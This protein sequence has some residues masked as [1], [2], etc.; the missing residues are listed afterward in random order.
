MY[1]PWPMVLRDARPH[2]AA[3]A[4]ALL[5]LLPA[6]APAVRAADTAA[7]TPTARAT[8][9]APALEPALEPAPTVGYAVPIGGA[10]RFDNDAVWSRLVQLSGGNGARWVVL[11]TAASDPAHTAAQIVAVLQRHGARAEPI[12]VAARL[13]PADVATEV[14]NPRWL[15]KVQA[16]RG[17]FF[18]GGAQERIVDA[19][20]PGGQSTPLLEAIRALQQRGGVVAGTSA[21]AAVMSSVMFRDAEDVMAVLRGSLRDGAEVDRGLGFVGAGLLVDQHFLRRGRI[22]RLLPL[23]VSREIRLGLGVDEDTAAIVHGHDVEVIGA[24]GAL[25]VDLTD[26][27]SDP[28]AGAFN[29]AGARLSYL[30]RGDH[31]DLLHRRV[32]PAAEKLAGQRLDPAARDFAPYH[33]AAPFFTDILADS[34][35]VSAMIHVV[36]GRDAEVRGLAAT[37]DRSSSAPSAPDF[38]FRLYRGMGTL[39][40]YTGEFGGEAYTLENVR[41]DVTPVRVAAPLYTPWQR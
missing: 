27:R 38:E 37:V 28:A 13:A 40:W 17:V 22:G 6:G 39:G 19:L 11:A 32:Q 12:A 41:L 29:V 24:R 7:T 15:R 23:M 25:F 20:L 2:A 10:L 33:A 36:D 18:A 21:G 16:A 1:Y 35:I 14:R 4:L 26:A 31:L 5:S 8:V 3:L 30:E 34:A 9:H